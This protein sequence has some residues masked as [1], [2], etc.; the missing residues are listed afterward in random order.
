MKRTIPCAWLLF[1]ASIL[2]LSG[3]EE[4]LAPESAFA[5]LDGGGLPYLAAPPT[6]APADP[7]PET[8][9]ETR[10]NI[11]RVKSDVPLTL[12]ARGHLDTRGISWGGRTAP[13]ARVLVDGRRLPVRK[14]RFKFSY[15]SGGS[16]DYSFDVVAKHQG[17]ESI[18]RFTVH[19]ALT[20]REKAEQWLAGARDP[21]YR[22]LEKDPDAFRGEKVKFRGKIF[23]IRESH[24]GTT[25]QMHVGRNWFGYTENNLFAVYPKRTSLVRG[26]V[27]TIYGVVLGAHTYRSQAGWILTV[28]M[29]LVKHIVR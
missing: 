16:Q 25:L 8:P 10:V 17:K 20:V 12:D 9:D 4:A 18:A 28:P 7:A 22:E 15:A 23:S 14:G 6:P 2:L 26:N 1:L 19:R 5:P 3:C 27:V 11:T 21:T 13:G 24:A 29:V